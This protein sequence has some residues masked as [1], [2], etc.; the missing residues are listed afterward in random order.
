MLYLSRS[1]FFIFLYLLIFV[2]FSLSD[3]PS[4]LQTFSCYSPQLL[5]YTWFFSAP[6]ATPLFHSLR[7]SHSLIWDMLDLVCLKATLL[8]PCLSWE[9]RRVSK[10]VS[11]FNWLCLLEC[12]SPSNFLFLSFTWCSISFSVCI[13]PLY[14]LKCLLYQYNHITPL[15][16]S[17]RLP[18]TIWRIKTSPQE[19]FL[20]KQH[21]LIF[22]C[23]NWQYWNN[24]V[25]VFSNTISLVIGKPVYMKMWTNSAW[26]SKKSH[27]CS[28]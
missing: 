4:I 5:H 12:C 3:S 21:T 10:T 8:S 16:G 17:K 19:P 15:R 25:V 28:E 14:W 20:L 6:T 27:S 11:P 13:P 26:Q 22:L 24:G 23:G 9:W 18:R 2:C 1:H 7:K